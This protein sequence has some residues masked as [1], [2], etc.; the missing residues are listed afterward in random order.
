MDRQVAI[1]FITS[2]CNVMGIP[3]P[4]MNGLSD[5]EFGDLYIRI[6]YE[7][8]MYCRSNGRNI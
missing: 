2:V 4:M 7:W 1:D 5:K 6:R 8:E 3:I